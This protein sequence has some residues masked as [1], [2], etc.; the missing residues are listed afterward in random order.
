MG[1]VGNKLG[2]L[3]ATVECGAI[4]DK[5]GARVPE[6]R[7]RCSNDD[8]G[9][10]DTNRVPKRFAVVV[11]WLD[12]RRLR[13]RCCGWAREHVD[14]RCNIES[15]GPDNKRRL[16]HG[17]RSAKIVRSNRGDKLRAIGTVGHLAGERVDAAV[18]LQASRRTTSNDRDAVLQH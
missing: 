1:H 9:A 15:I 7:V 14:R 4:E 5:D 13:A 12:H 6:A 8:G 11:W 3:R 10:V 2:P 16:I 18:V 17:K